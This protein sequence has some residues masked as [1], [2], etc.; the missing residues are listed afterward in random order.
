[1][2]HLLH[3]TSARY[4]LQAFHD[5]DDKHSGRNSNAKFFPYQTTFQNQKFI[6]E[7]DAMAGPEDKSVSI[8]IK[9]PLES[10]KSYAISSKY[11]RN[12]VQRDRKQNDEVVFFEENILVKIARTS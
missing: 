9:D 7:H 3:P 1:M 10:P 5:K 12:G 6:A 11:D 4:V 2:V 8:A